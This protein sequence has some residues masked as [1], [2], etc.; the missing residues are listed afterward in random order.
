[1]E[2]E[3]R[4]LYDEGFAEGVEHALDVVEDVLY[5]EL[6][7]ENILSDTEL[8]E[9]MDK[10]RATIGEFEVDWEEVEEEEEEFEDIDIDEEE[11][12]E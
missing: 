9:L 2:K 7:A 8:E 12:E 5:E 6:V 11:E 3:D 10:I 4:D 1:M